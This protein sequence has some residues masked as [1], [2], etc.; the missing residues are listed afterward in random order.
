MLK[1]DPQTG[2]DMNHSCLFILTFF[3]L[4]NS[5]AGSEIFQIGD[6]QSAGIFG[7][8]W[9]SS[10]RSNQ[11][12]PFLLIARGG[13]TTESWL[14]YKK[15]N[16]KF[17]I[18]ARD[19]KNFYVERDKLPS[20]ENLLAQVSP[21]TVIVQLGGNMV[22]WSNE[23]IKA[24]VHEF[25]ILVNSYSNNCIWIAPP[26]GHARPQ[27]RFN[28]FYPILKEAV[29][30]EGCAFIDSRPYTYYPS[31]RG[32]GIHYDSLGLQG[33]YLVN[34]WINGLYQQIGPLL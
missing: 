16:G 13:A 14:D 29:E 7:K 17:R 12:K 11:R 10:V 5:F 22:R 15:L 19:G 23:D 20:L 25:L 27:P 26:N 21:Q 1:I 24:S 9:H 30:N 3:I 31:W 18:F 33:Y 4:A 34:K 8:S 6:S 28:E 2:P 32:D